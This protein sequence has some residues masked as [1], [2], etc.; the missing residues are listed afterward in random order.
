MPMDIF[1]LLEQTGA[2]R[3]AQSGAHKLTVMPSRWSLSVTFCWVD[4]IMVRTMCLMYAF[5]LT[6]CAILILFLKKY[7]L[8]KHESLLFLLSQ[9]LYL[10]PM[11]WERRDIWERDACVIKTINPD[12][13]YCLWKSIR[14]SYP[15]PIHS[16]ISGN[17]LA[18][19]I[20]CA[21]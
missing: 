21:S 10:C 3:N 15:C 16:S 2:N 4:W 5:I 11:C 12:P 20:S 18:I 19:V 17:L 6:K 13:R 7:I 1:Y 14:P 8:G 9:N